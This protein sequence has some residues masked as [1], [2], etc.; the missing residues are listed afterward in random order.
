MNNITKILTT[1][2]II[3]V[4]VVIYSK[5]KTNPSKQVKIKKD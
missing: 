3:G 4:S 2:A 1:L 5:Y